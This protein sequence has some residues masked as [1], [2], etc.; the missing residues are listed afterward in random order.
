MAEEGLHATLTGLLTY[1]HQAPD[2]TTRLRRCQKLMDAIQHLERDIKEIRR[3]QM[4][5][6]HENEPALVS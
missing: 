3:Q 1:I 4:V 5:S 6:L 2:T